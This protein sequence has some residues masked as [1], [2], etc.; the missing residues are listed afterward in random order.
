[1]DLV[2]SEAGVA[3]GFDRSELLSGRSCISF[4]F[5]GRKLI[6][7]CSAPRLT[8]PP[9]SALSDYRQWALLL[10]APCK[11]DLERSL[12]LESRDHIERLCG[13]GVLNDLSLEFHVGMRT[14]LSGNLELGHA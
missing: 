3:F 2:F 10:G 14:S 11:L 6:S 8:T 5:D 12:P 4:G 1:M 13:T 7:S 9:C